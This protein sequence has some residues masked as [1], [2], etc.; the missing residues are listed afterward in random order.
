MKNI[1]LAVRLNSR[2]AIVS[3]TIQTKSA[4]LPYKTNFLGKKIGRPSFGSAIQAYCKKW[5]IRI[6]FNNHQYYFNIERTNKPICICYS[7]T[8]RT[9]SN[10]LIKQDRKIHSQ[11]RFWDFQL[12]LRKSRKIV[13]SL[14]WSTHELAVSDGKC[15]IRF[16]WPLI[17]SEQPKLYFIILSTKPKP[18]NRKIICKW[19]SNKKGKGK[20]LLLNI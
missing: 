4:R 13:L 9:V 11:L 6:L 17:I 16:K 7:S 19:L 15:Y 10:Q 3:R 18:D 14:W 8:N 2:K 5:N 12:R 20:V 1:M